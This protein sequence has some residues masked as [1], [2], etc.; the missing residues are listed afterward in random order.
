MASQAL[1]P[2]EASFPQQLLK[3]RE[4]R[5][6][7]GKGGGVIEGVRVREG[8]TQVHCKEG[9]GTVKRRGWDRLKRDKGG[10]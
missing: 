9:V 7:Q 5:E 4:E 6:E 10:E 8:D 3:R 1:S 2:A